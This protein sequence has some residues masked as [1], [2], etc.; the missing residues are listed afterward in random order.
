MKIDFLYHGG[1]VG[2]SGYITL[3]FQETMPIQASAALPVT[4]GHGSA[5][6]ER[7]CHRDYFSF[8]RAETHVV[9]SFSEKDQAWGTLATS[10]IEGI[11]IL[12][13]VTCDKIV[14]RITSKHP[15]DGSEPSF[16]PLGSRV[17]NLR[18]A[19]HKIDVEVATDIYTEHNT[20]SKL[21]KAHAAKKEVRDTILS[22]GNKLS[23]PGEMTR[24]SLARNIDKLPGGLTR[25][26]HGIYVPHFGTV[27]VGEYFVSATMHRLLM[28]H[29]DLGCSIEGCYGAGGADGN[30][31]PPPR[32]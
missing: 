20:W 28:L 32:T 22:K 1:A 6:A 5:F 16:I 14:A 25:N 10:T 15:K 31:S 17:E 8:E 2:A 13:V 30:G 26:G 24:V 11:N 27:Y 29:V 12:N 23:A 19:G 21:T 3:P 4:G 18:I 7:F 9:G